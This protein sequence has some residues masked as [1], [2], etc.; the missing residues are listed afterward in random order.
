MGLPFESVSTGTSFESKVDSN[1]V[2]LRYISLKYA[3]IN[4]FYL[5]NMFL[6]CH[7]YR[8][9]LYFEMTAHLLF[10]HQ[11]THCKLIP[12]LYWQL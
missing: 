11:V 10:W 4:F 1:I 9:S 3:C 12:F 6:Q 2:P 8:C 7:L 5:L